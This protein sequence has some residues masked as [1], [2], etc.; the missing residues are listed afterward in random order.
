M[1]EEGKG[2]Q[3]FE[4]IYRRIERALEVMRGLKYIF[5]VND[6]SEAFSTAEFDKAT[7]ERVVAAIAGVFE[8]RLGEMKEVT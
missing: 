6:R 4:D 3:E 2:T 1:D 8:E 5:I 7:G